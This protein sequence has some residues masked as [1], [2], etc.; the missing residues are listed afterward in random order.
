MP[1]RLAR[2]IPAE[3]E[4]DSI[5]DIKPAVKQVKKSKSLS[6]YTDGSAMPNPGAGGAAAIF[7]KNDEI[8]KTIEHYGGE[9]TTNNK[10]ELQAILKVYPHLSETENVT[11]F[12]DSLYVKNGLDSWV[13]EWEKNGWM[14]KD[15]N[16]VK[17]KEEWMQLL[18]YKRA[19]PLVKIEWVK[20]HSDNKWNNLVD[21]LA[22]KVGKSGDKSGDKTSKTKTAKKSSI[23]AKY[24]LYI[25][26]YSEKSFVVMGDVINHSN[27]LASLGGKFCYNLKTGQGWLF[28][29]VKKESVQKY[30]DTGEI[31]PYQYT[32]EEKQQFRDREAQKL[33]QKNDDKR[34]MIRLFGELRGAFEPLEDYEG[35]SIINVI[36]QLQD[37]YIGK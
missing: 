10:M 1:P 14:K 31:V 34:E 8:I 2:R 19:F 35:S 29:K 17:N 16:P 33:Q 32:D 9:Y 11:I 37:K 3:S 23:E 5:D 26:D 27:A 25:M 30:I 18:D 36:K 21:E 6:I 22:K 15:G 20:A 24:N 28:T 7:I 4:T 13:K 12:T